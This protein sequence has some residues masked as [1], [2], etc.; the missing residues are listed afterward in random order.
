VTAPDTYATPNEPTWCAGCG[1]FGLLQALNAAYTGLGLSFEHLAVVWGIGCHGNGADFTRC[2]G[3]H[4]LHGRALP[5][6]TGLVL[7]NPELK[8]VVE[9]GDGDAYGIGLG[10]FAHSCRRNIDLTVIAHDNQIY[11]LT[12]GQ[13]S[14]TT[15]QHMATVSTPAGVLEQPVNT[16]GLA[17]AEGATFVARGFTG[18]V[19]HLT[20]LMTA[21]LEHRGFALVDVFQ[22][23]VT[24]NKL[25]TASWFRQRVYKLEDSGWDSTNRAKALE[26]SLTTFHDMSC[27]PEQCKIPLGVIYREEG[28]P[29]Y[30]DGLPQLTG[31]LWKTAT[32]PR[33]ISA[34]LASMT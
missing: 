28:R 25:N 26:L 15:E 10:H 22:P 24:W 30:S 2:Q 14:P 1:N 6:A 3:F 27:T 13:A 17:V 7:S 20:G 23:C 33:D 5:V 8:V 32:A 29:T 11:G 9:V 31:P 12:T 34:T 21:A 18:D 19:P 16:I 4:A